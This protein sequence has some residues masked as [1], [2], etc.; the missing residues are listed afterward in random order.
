MG[1]I[2]N[3]INMALDIFTKA[4]LEAASCMKKTLE[5]LCVAEETPAPSLLFHDVINDVRIQNGSHACCQISVEVWS[6]TPCETRALLRIQSPD[7]LGRQWWDVSGGTST[8]KRRT[9]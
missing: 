1:A 6:P 3:D 8:V 4:L 2:E 5:I 7:G 9:E